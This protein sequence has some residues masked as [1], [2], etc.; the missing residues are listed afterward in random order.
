MMPHPVVNWVI[1]QSRLSAGRQQTRHTRRKV[2]YTGV[3]YRDLVL[4]WGALMDLIGHYDYS[5]G[6]VAISSPR[7][8]YFSLFERLI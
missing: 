1:F 7:I 2:G 4:G 8:N 6:D 3:R 5:L